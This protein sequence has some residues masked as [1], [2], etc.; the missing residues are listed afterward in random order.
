MFTAFNIY[1]TKTNMPLYHRNI[2][3]D[4]FF[5]TIYLSS[6]AADFNEYAMEQSTLGS[7]AEYHAYEDAWGVTFT[8]IKAI[9]FHVIFFQVCSTHSACENEL[10]DST[11]SVLMSC[12]ELTENLNNSI[13]YN[14][15]LHPTLG[16]VERANALCTEIKT[17]PDTLQMDADSIIIDSS[18]STPSPFLKVR[19]PLSLMLMNKPHL[20]QKWAPPRS[21][22]AHTL[23][24]RITRIVALS[25]KFATYQSILRVDMQVPQQSFL[26][27]SVQNP[28]T[29]AGYSAPEFGAVKLEKF[30]DMD[31]CM[32][33]CRVDTLRKPY[34]A[35][36]PTLDQLNTSHPAHQVL[37]QRYVCATFPSDWAVF[38]F[39]F[40]LETNMLAGQ[41]Y[42]QVFFDAIDALALKL[43]QI[44]SEHVE[45]SV[46]LGI[47]N[48]I[49]YPESFEAQMRSMASITCALTQCLNTFYPNTEGWVNTNYIF[50]R[51]RLLHTMQVHTVRVD[52]MLI[53]SNMR[54][55]Q[56]S[57]FRLHV[58][59]TLRSAVE[60]HASTLDFED[61]SVQV[62]GIEEVDM[63]R[64][65][66]FASPAA[67]YIP[68][69]PVTPSTKPSTKEWSFMQQFK[70]SEEDDPTIYFVVGIITVVLGAMCFLFCAWGR[71]RKN[72]RQR[73]GN[74]YQPAEL[75]T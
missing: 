26:T 73:H 1:K 64:V 5:L 9:D 63:E 35:I 71:K 58:L 74:V 4:V 22:F 66:G 41:G 68:P 37:P 38:F 31:R 2:W 72:Q 34:N 60:T 3:L 23:I 44:M 53:T 11:A 40:S 28:C 15:Y 32:L 69:P 14:S 57:T 50:N 16:T 61:D 7:K 46:S 36:P 75:A 10:S 24:L 13:W 49:Y 21:N 20:L 55:L 56:E 70:E 33:T 19:Q 47:P 45:N 27:F 51:R 54:V 67:L 25:Q 29:A 17:H 18:T 30:D 6:C 59:S 39:A 8:N 48:T 65:L 62:V 12:G 52:G 42:T 43:Q